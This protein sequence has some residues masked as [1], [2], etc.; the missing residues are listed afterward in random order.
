MA[1]NGVTLTPTDID[2]LTVLRYISIQGSEGPIQADKV[3]AFLEGGRDRLRR[4]IK[5]GVTIT[6][7]SDNYLGLRWPQGYGARRV[8]FSY[9][10]AGMS[11][12][13][14]LQAA[15]INDARLLGREGQI[16]VIK[17]GAWADI[18]ALDGNPETDFNAIE[19]V[20]FVMKG[21]TVYVGR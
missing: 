17:P 7:G 20:K 16:G 15:T 18:I 3:H 12:G 10:T 14:V 13:E 2:S 4:A 5:A 6:A 19:R 8:L 11:A 1:K 9:R 21:G